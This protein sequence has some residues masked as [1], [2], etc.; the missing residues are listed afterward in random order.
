[1]C[2]VPVLIPPHPVPTSSAVTAHLHVSMRLCHISSSISP[3]RTPDLLESFF[4]LSGML[5]HPVVGEDPQGSLWDRDNLQHHWEPSRGHRFRVKGS[6]G[7]RYFL[8]M[9]GVTEMTHS[10]IHPPRGL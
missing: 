5:S 8:G 10:G 1:M 2:V 7:V 4:S 3:T 6:L 9:S